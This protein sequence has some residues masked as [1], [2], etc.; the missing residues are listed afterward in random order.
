MCVFQPADSAKSA[1]AAKGEKAVVEGPSGEGLVG[2]AE[3]VGGVTEEEEEEDDDEEQQN[4]E[5]EGPSAAEE[6]REEEEEE[7]EEEAREGDQE[8]WQEL[9]DQPVLNLEVSPQ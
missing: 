9:Q 6:Q 4:E 7:E 5:G 1:G 8:G 2:M 3:A